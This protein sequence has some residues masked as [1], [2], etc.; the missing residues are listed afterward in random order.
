MRLNT[1]LLHLIGIYCNYFIYMLHT[2]SHCGII[3]SGTCVINLLLRYAMERCDSPCRL[4]DSNDDDDD[5]EIHCIIL[6]LVL[7]NTACVCIT[8]FLP[9]GGRSPIFVNTETLLHMVSQ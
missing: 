6:L 9:Y 3:V 2:F 1:D 8:V 4:H 5:D 7:H